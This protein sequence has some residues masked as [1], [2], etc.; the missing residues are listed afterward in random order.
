MVVG[1]TFEAF[2]AQAGVHIRGFLAPASSW[3]DAL[4]LQLLQLHSTP[5]L[6]VLARCSYAISLDHTW[7]PNIREKSFLRRNHWPIAH[8]IAS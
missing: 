1:E 2:A 6:I 4:V 8:S 3:W 5:A 7:L